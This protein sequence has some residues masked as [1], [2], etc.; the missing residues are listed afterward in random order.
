MAETGASVA[1]RWFVGTASAAGLHVEGNP[2]QDAAGFATAG[3]SVVVAVADGHSGPRHFRSERGAQFAVDAACEAGSE[4]AGELDA[5]GNLEE[6]VALITD[7]LLPDI[8]ELWEERVAADVTGDPFAGDGTPLAARADAV[9]PYGTTLLLALVSPIWAVAAQIGDGDIVVVG[10]GRQVNC[11][12]PGD[13]MIEGSHTTSLCQENAAASFRIAAIDLIGFPIAAV[14]LA[15]DGYGDSQAESPW[16][17]A[18]GLGIIQLA[19]DQGIAYV[20]GQV[21]EWAARCASADGAGDDTSLAL[22]INSTAAADR[23]P[24]SRSRLPS[25][26][27]GRLEGGEAQASI[28]GLGADRGE[29][30]PRIEV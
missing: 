14:L 2:N 10:G 28:V 6:V 25:R 5:L 15:T 20:T 26:R 16:Q 12:V 29:G 24:R 19:T 23:P 27:S 1:G 4:L 21:G 13:P 9:V 3:D 11:P 8:V 18:V 22:V 7:R 30:R 17:P